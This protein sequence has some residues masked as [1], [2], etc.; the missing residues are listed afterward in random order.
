SADLAQRVG[1]ARTAANALGNL[2][3]VRK[4]RGEL[5]QAESL[6]V[7]AGEIRVRTGDTRGLAADENNRGLIAQTLGDFA[8]AERAFETALDAN[9]RA[10]RAEPAAVNL[11]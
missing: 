2:A 4:D 9:R 3:S 7:R 5:R 1:D 8:A 10:G 11:I 6:Y